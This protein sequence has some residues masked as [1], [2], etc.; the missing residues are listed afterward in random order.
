MRQLETTPLAQSPPA[1][2]IQTSQPKLFTLHFLSLRNPSKGSGSGFLS[3]LSSATWPFPLWPH[4]TCSDPPVSGSYGNNKLLPSKPP[5]HFLWGLHWRYHVVFNTYILSAETLL[6]N[7]HWASAARE[8]PEMHLGQER[9]S[10][11]SQ[12]CEV[13]LS[14]NELVSERGRIQMLCLANSLTENKEEPSL[15]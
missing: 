1:S 13:L 10:G 11:R 4:M 15:H 9:H 14:R 2:I 5:P 7:C 8:Q 3:F 12:D 6:E